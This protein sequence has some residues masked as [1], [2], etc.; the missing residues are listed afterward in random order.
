MNISRILLFLLT[1][2]LTSSCISRKRLIYFQEKKNT[3]LDTTDAGFIKVTRSMYQLQQ[4]DMLMITIKSL[5]EE[6]NKL[7]QDAEYGGMSQGG[8]GAIGNM[9]GDAIFFLQGQTIG[10][11]GKIKIPIIGNLHAEGLTE[12]EVQVAIDK[13]LS[14]YFK[15]S[16]VFSRVRQA[17]IR[18]SVV[19]E[20]GRPGRHVIL[21]P[22]LNII[23]ALANAG[24]IA[25]VGDRRNVQIIR[26][27]PQGLRVFEVDLTDHRVLND[28]MFFIQPND[29]IQ[30]KPLRQKSYGIGTTGSQTITTTVSII[31][32]ALTLILLFSRTN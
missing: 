4:G 3:S 23:E 28:P 12:E 32:S 20:V 6:A 30:V 10:S 26:Q 8:M 25:F 21:A 19:G 14:L 13:R 22:Y 17:G 2:A 5:D 16:T 27:Y 18:Y 1:I 31:T 24:D 11:D 15:E 29:I 7:F 9:G